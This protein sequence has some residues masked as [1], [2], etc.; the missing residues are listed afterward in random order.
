MKKLLF[1]WSELKSTFWF[2]PIFIVLVGIGLS[3]LTISIDNNLDLEIE[4]PF[5]FFFPASAESARTLLSTVAGAMITVAG[6]VFSM[7][8]VAL[9]LAS[10]Q[11]GARLLRNFMHVRLNQ[12]VLGTYV[13]LFTYCLIVLN[14]VRDIDDVVFVPEIS[15]L[16]A[17]IAS[18]SNIILLVVFIHGIATSIQADK[19]ISNISSSLE[20]QMDSLFP[21]EMGEAHG[22]ENKIADLEAELRK[23]PESTSIIAEGDGYLQ[24]LDNEFFEEY[25]NENNSL[26]VIDCKPGSY[27][28]K[29]MTVIKIYSHQTVELKSLK[30]FHNS[31]ILGKIRTPQQDLE[32]SIHQIV[33]VADKALSPG[34]N[35]PYTAIASIDNLTSIICKLS[36]LRFPSKFR[37]NDE[38]RLIIIA[39]PLT[40]EG[41]VD[42]A[43]HSIRQFAS[44]SPI[45]A[46]RLME[47]LVTIHDFA[48]KTMDKIVIERHMN[49]M[50]RLAE[51]SF[52]EKNDIQDMRKRVDHIPLSKTKV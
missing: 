32:F 23:Y 11:Y 14:V 20:D 36:R 45:V 21:Q 6:T 27:I 12:V 49:M 38:E 10:S 39:E 26:I 33:E 41:M 51:R 2:I 48:N 5:E 43:F 34:I 35:D 3:I 31:I 19:I 46:I 4:G 52:E 42:A 50:L 15:V 17:I 25:A 30:K 29:G 37:Y 47:A 28:V 13:A 40:F 7:T 44:G 22:K 16:V 24:Y 18:L 8:L 9:T 1:L